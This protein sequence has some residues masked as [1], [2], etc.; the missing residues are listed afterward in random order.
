MDNNIVA[1][2]DF[3]N[4]ATLHNPTKEVI[5]MYSHIEEIQEKDPFGNPMV[6]PLFSHSSIPYLLGIPI[7][8]LHEFNFKNNSIYCFM[9]HHNAEL[10][11]K[12]L[13]L[14]NEKI[15]ES[16]R[17]KK[18][19]LVLDNTLEG[20]SIEKFLPALFTSLDNLKI[21]Y[22]QVHFVTNNL[23][24]KEF[25]RKWCERNEILFK[26]LNIKTT[27]KSFIYRLR[28]SDLCDSSIKIH[29]FPWNIYDVDRLVRSGDL[30]DKV[31]LNK[32]IEYK[33]QNLSS[34]KH[35]LKVNRTG[36]PERSLFMLYLNKHKMLDK[37]KI[38]FPRLE[39]LNEFETLL[40]TKYEEEIKQDNIDSLLEKVPF[41]IDESDINNHGEPGYGKG[42]FNADLPFN[43]IHYRNTF[44][45]IVMCAFPHVKNACHL[46]SSTYNPIYCGHPY[47][48]FGPYNHLQNLKQLGFKTFS[49]WWDE[50]YDN[51]DHHVDRLDKILKLVEE[52]YKYSKSD[53][54]EMYKEMKPVLQHNSNL[55]K[56]SKYENELRWK[57][58]Q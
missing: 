42:K 57:I 17:S 47:I 45:S 2:T 51:Y 48:G 30:P 4:K 38:S 55:I 54:L 44:I 7:I 29:P 49:K 26:D 11:V 35:F 5:D 36:R 40:K 9:L 14:L 28:N 31:D 32:E 20:D 16:V 25:F 41:D 53:M 43:P 56:N 58:L 10:A 8:D 46:H 13:Y 27:K 50:S 21:P 24:A 3:V 19:K 34:M 15:L 23:E 6:R 39:Q 33:E 52:L 1:I 37:F 18:T 12:H 22:E